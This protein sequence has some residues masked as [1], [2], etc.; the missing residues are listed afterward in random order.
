MIFD[1]R[2]LLRLSA[3]AQTTGLN[4]S[5]KGKFSRSEEYIFLSHSNEDLPLAEGL[6]QKLRGLGLKLYFDLDDSGLAYPPGRSTAIRIKKC[7]DN[8]AAFILLATEK[9]IRESRWCPWELGYADGIGIPIGI[10]QTKD[11]EGKCWGAEYLQMYESVENLI[12]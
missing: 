6:V 8:A 7:I 10:A 4:E 5:A 1:Q 3:K 9:S 11:M 2:E 12:S